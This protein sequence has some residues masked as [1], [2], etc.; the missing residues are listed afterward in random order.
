MAT[1]TKAAKKAK[2]DPLFPKPVKAVKGKKVTAKFIS[3]KIAATIPTQS[4]GNVHPEIEVQAATYEEARDFAMPFIEQLYSH[5][6]E[7]K[8]GF[9]GRVSV[10]E[11][12][13]AAAPE[14]PVAPTAAP[15]V[16]KEAA[17]AAEAP[18][19]A[20]TPKPEPVLKA[21]KAIALAATEEAAVLIQD[22]IEKSVKIAPE[23][24]P[25]LLELCL[26]RRTALAPKDL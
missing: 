19:A 3:L 23:F 10:V 2:V 17:K 24:K 13:V 14:K 26:K 6:C 9:L 22:Q 8:P 21:E 18:V 1:K 7:S 25:A 11:K 15:V 12:V 4:F 16:A 20:A 5:Y